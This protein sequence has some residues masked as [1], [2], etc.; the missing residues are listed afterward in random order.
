VT[1]FVRNLAADLVAKRLWPV[2]AALVI[3][4]VAIPVVLA[5]GGEETPIRRRRPAC[6]PQP[7][8]PTVGVAEER[9]RGGRGPIRP[10]ILRAVQAKVPAAPAAGSVPSGA[11]APSGATLPTGGASVGL[12]TSAAAGA[13]PAGGDS[14]G[15]VGPRSTSRPRRR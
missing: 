3:A 12:P 2:A 13:R 5:G 1:A 8:Q 10:P 14:W 6:R 4:L 7:A 9:S 15:D 11:T